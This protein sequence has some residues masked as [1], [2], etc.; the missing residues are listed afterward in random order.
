MNSF[1]NQLSQLE[2]KILLFE[3]TNLSVSKTAVGWH[4]EHVLKTSLIIIE[5]VKISNPND[6]Q[7]KFNKYK[8]LFTILGFIPRGRARAPKVAL[9]DKIISEESLL[10]SIKKIKLA[11]ENWSDLDKNAHF[12][13]PYFGKLNKKSTGWFLSL[14]AKHHLKIIIDI[15][16]A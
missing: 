11:L 6:Y 12:P 10:I 14:H 3:K 1:L 13:H 8:L 15:D 4:I 16:N 2:S 9:P 7:Y 5:S